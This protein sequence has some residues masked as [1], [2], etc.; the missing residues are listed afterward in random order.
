MNSKNLFSFKCWRIKYI[1]DLTY[2]ECF[3]VY[4]RTVYL[5]WQGRCEG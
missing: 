2:L 1:I 5:F 4:K 3:R